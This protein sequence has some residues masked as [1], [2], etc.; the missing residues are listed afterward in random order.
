MFHLLERVAA[1]PRGPGEPPST[2][3]AADVDAV[4]ADPPVTRAILERV[5]YTLDLDPAYSV[6]SHVVAYN[7][8]LPAGAGGVPAAELRDQCVERWPAGF[9]QM[10]L[11]DFQL[12]ADEMIGLGVL[13]KEGNTYRL[14]SPNVARLLGSKDDIEAVLDDAH[15]LEPTAKFEPARWRREVQP[16]S[17]APAFRSPLS[18]A[19]LNDLCAIR[20]QTRIVAA[21]AASG[22]AHVPEAIAAAHSPRSTHH[23]IQSWH[24]PKLAARYFRPLGDGRHRSVTVML[25]GAPHV[26][27]LELVEAAAAATALQR[28]RGT[29]AD[30]LAITF[31]AHA[32]KNGPL[33]RTAGASPLQDK[34]PIVAAG[35]W[36]VE[37]IANFGRDASGVPFDTRTA[38]Q[39]VHDAT[40]GWDVLVASAAA[41]LARGVSLED[42]LER[43][44]IDRLGA[45]IDL[46]ADPVLEAAWREAYDGGL[47]ATSADPELVAEYLHGR[48]AITA[49]AQTA[50]SARGSLGVADTDDGTS[51]VTHLLHTGL[52]VDTGD[53]VTVEPI[54]ARLHF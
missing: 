16:T 23:V 8:H 31:V 11:P 13:A 3:T 26:K 45:E 42:A 7:H 52:L 37:A 48:A 2:I 17:G 40:G 39:R 54:A 34:V 32:T 24:E 51:L 29:G 33:L 10:L 50:R 6:I 19:Q 44:P 28:R 22:L 25:D 49:A 15:K 1:R 20:F 47:C 12:I 27:A 14:R 9:G 30:T 5:R 43:L 38:A 4:W 41:Q 21:T 35:P 36:T 53:G 18:D 46:A